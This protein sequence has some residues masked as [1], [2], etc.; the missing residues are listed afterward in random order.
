MKRV[1]NDFRPFLGPFCAGTGQKLLAG[2]A[3]QRWQAS[4]PRS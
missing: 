4:K 3:L 1:L 2:A